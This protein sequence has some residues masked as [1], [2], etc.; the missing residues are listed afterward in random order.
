V[1]NIERVSLSPLD[2]PLLLLLTSQ[3]LHTNKSKVKTK[4]E[5]RK[6]RKRTHYPTKCGLGSP[7]VWLWP[8]FFL[9]LSSFCLFL[10]YY[11]CR[12]S[13]QTHRPAASVGLALL[14]CGCGRGRLTHPGCQRATFCQITLIFGEFFRTNK[15]MFFFYY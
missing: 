6:Q 1:I 15:Y 14:Q 5:Q 13:K 11:S 4:E 8:S 2:F 10:I 9:F 3:R 7:P 12:S